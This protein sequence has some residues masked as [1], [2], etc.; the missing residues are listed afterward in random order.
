VLSREATNSNFKVFGLIRPGLEPTLTITP[1]VHVHFSYDLKIV[2]HV[3]KMVTLMLLF[4]MIKKSISERDILIFHL[5]YV[6]FVDHCL[7]F[8][9]FTIVWPLIDSFWLPFWYLLTFLKCLIFLCRMAK[10]ESDANYWL[11]SAKTKAKLFF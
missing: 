10:V 1:T 8:C 11:R 5:F 2:V 6:N 3:Q 7:S 4:N 9:L